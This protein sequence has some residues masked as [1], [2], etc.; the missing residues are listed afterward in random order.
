ML[1]PAKSVRGLPLRRKECQRQC[2]TDCSPHFLSPC[3]A[4]RERDREN[5]E[6]V[7]PGKSKGVRGRCVKM[8]FYFS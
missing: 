6:E 5:H 2:L 1:E 4:G 7:K 8:Q 3:A